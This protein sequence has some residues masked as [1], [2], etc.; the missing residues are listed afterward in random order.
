MFRLEAGC[1]VQFKFRGYGVQFEFR[2]YNH[3]NVWSW[4][5]L[6]CNTQYCQRGPHGMQARGWFVRLTEPNHFQAALWRQTS[7]VSCFTCIVDKAKYLFYAKWSVSTKIITFPRRQFRINVIVNRSFQATLSD[8]LKWL[9]WR[10]NDC[11]FWFVCC[12]ASKDEK[13]RISPNAERF[14]I[15]QPGNRVYKNFQELNL[16]ACKGVAYHNHR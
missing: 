8:R 3:T 15:N 2:G 9:Q 7:H 6:C 16:T 5:G 1:R 13:V 14:L 12:K 11:A 10:G 4:C